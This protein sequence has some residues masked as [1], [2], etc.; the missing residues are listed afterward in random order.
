MFINVNFIDIL[1]SF[2]WSGEGAGEDKM[3][4]WLSVIMLEKIW[5]YC[6]KDIYCCFSVRELKFV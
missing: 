2:F 5:S 4:K 6:S 1:C 3:L